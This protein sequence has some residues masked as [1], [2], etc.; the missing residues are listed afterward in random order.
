MSFDML[1]CD[2]WLDELIDFYQYIIILLIDAG[3]LIP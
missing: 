2:C 1:K 3:N